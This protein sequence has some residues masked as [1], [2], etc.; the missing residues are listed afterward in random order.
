M[1]DLEQKGI[2]TVGVDCNPDNPGFRSRYA[3]SYLCPNPDKEPENW[4]AFMLSLSAAMGEKPVLI[5]ASDIF[6]SAIGKHAK[7]L[8]DHFIFSEAGAALQASLATKETQYA[9]AK[10]YGLP[11]PRAAYI[12]SPEDMER[13]CKEARFPALLKPRHQR[14]WQALPEDNPFRQCKTVSAASP[15][16]MLDHYSKVSALVPQAVT[17]EEIVGPDSAKY[18]YLSVYAISGQRLGACVVQELRAYPLLYGCAT[19]V[20]P[21]VDE[22]ID[23]VCNKFLLSIG[24]K[25]ICE[26]E[27]KRD[28]RDG[29]LLL[30]EVNPRYSGTGDCAKYTGV[31]TGYLHYLDLIGQTPAPVTP[32]R[33][34]FRH[35]MLAADLAAFPKYLEEGQM[36]WKD[37]IRSLSGPMEYFDFDKG[38]FRIARVTGMKGAR[39]LLSGLWRNW[40]SGKDSAAKHT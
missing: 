23:S 29:K 11:C 25:G 20:E 17:Q 21:V 19:L 36:G 32:T 8:S 22:E 34:G 30:I 18:C 33:F 38:D 4:L 10:E 31:E 27:L 6:V 26:I 3:R 24:Y 7:A 37:W 16:E 13:F 1:R 15:E 35:A 28:I 5:P 40:R 39:A 14:E 2:R 9:L 12:Q